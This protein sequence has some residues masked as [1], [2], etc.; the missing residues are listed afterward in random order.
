MVSKARVHLEDDSWCATHGLDRILHRHYKKLVAPRLTSPRSLGMNSLW[1]EIR[2][3]HVGRV[4]IAYGVVGWLLV[5]VADFATETFG[6]PPWVLQVFS[7]FVLLGLPVAILLA[8]AFDLT[9]DGIQRTAAVQEAGESPPVTRLGGRTLFTTFLFIALAI[10]VWLQFFGPTP[11]TRNTI[12]GGLSISPA[13]PPAA[14]LL[15]L[16]MTFP[17]DAPLALIGAAE[18]GNGKQA[19]AI[20]PNGRFLVYVGANDG[21]YEL[22]LRDLF[23]D[24]I[25]RLPG[26]AGAFNPFFAPNNAWIGFFI[27]NELFKVHVNGSEPVFVSDATNSVGASWTSSDHIVMALDEGDRLVKVS[28]DGS[29]SRDLSGTEVSN[30]MF[31]FAIRG[32]EKAVTNGFLVDLETGNT[33]ALP[34]RGGTDTRHING[35]LFFE[36]FGSLFAARFD[37]SRNVLESNPIP[38]ITGL[39]SEIWG[40]AQWSVSD[41]GTLV[42]MQGGPAGSNPMYWV[43]TGDPVALDLPVRHRGSFEISPDGEYLAALEFNGAASEIWVYSLDGGRAIKLT[44]DGLNSGPIFWSPDSTSVYYVKQ[45]DTSFT[46]YRSGLNSQLPPERVLPDAYVNMRASSI[47]ADGRL[48]GLNGQDGIGIFAPETGQLDLIPT[49]SPDDWGTA[50]SPDG[51]AVVYTSSIT[52]S[53]H[54]FLQPLPTTGERYQVSRTDGSEEPRWSLD[55]TRVYYRNGN[56]IMSVDVALDPDIQIGDAEVFYAGFFENVG[57]R[58]YAMHPDD[59]RALVIRSENLASSV[60]VVSNWFAKVERLIQESEAEV[61]Q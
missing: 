56:R 3:R 30:W 31:P 37:P 60:R 11:V 59:E 38:V 58:S 10:A 41:Q 17:A 23:E 26:T 42:Y 8:W 28:S 44:T 14:E 12:D 1:N 27:G 49:A 4:T 54:I 5:Q 21:S 57:G 34:V 15:H 25:T 39:R 6:A 40:A 20:S 16:D 48:L 45:G 19:F 22:Y 50:V 2:R 29:N 61:Q 53:Y 55:G 47:T 18:L 13:P 51:R 35:Y 43:G 9:P 33:Q 32:E 24:R 46:T 52:G 7:V 36:S